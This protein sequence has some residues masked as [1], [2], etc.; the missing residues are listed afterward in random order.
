MPQ[1]NHAH[2]VVRV[3]T[4]VMCATFLRALTT[5]CADLP[6]SALVAACGSVVSIFVVLGL[7]VIGAAAATT[8]GVGGVGSCPSVAGLQPVLIALLVT[9]NGFLGCKVGQLLHF[10]LAPMLQDSPR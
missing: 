8:T 6:S 4:D 3:F 2:L 7:G 5:T 10:D 9:Q 1:V